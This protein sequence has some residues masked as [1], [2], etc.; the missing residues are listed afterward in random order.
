MCTCNLMWYCDFNATF[1][2]TLEQFNMFVCLFYR[3]SASDRA[4]GRVEAALRGTDLTFCAQSGGALLRQVSWWD[5]LPYHSLWYTLSGSSWKR[6]WPSELYLF[7]FVLGKF[8]CTWCAFFS[9]GDGAWYR[10]MINEISE[11]E[12]SVNY[13][14]YGSCMKVKNKNL[15]PITPRLLTLPFQ[16]VRCSLAGTVCACE[17]ERKRTD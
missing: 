12:T 15:R 4:W 6:N 16:A 3:P 10:A 5:N 17:R 13:V 1:Y 2:Q 11:D 8:S 7:L 14:D 9:P